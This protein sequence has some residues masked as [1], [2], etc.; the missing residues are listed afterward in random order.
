MSLLEA[1]HRICFREVL[2][3]DKLYIVKLIFLFKDTVDLQEPIFLDFFLFHVKPSIAILTTVSKKT[4]VKY[5]SNRELFTKAFSNKVLISQKYLSQQTPWSLEFSRVNISWFQLHLV[6]F[7]ICLRIILD[8]EWESEKRRRVPG[9]KF[10]RSL[11]KDIFKKF[12]EEGEKIPPWWIRD[13]RLD[14]C[15]ANINEFCRGGFSRF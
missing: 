3:Y 6:I 7:A 13:L 5:R 11:A 15:L 8:C 10:T 4:F 14:I 2:C 9:Q 1:R 12:D